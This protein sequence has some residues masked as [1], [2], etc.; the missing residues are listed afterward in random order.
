MPSFELFRSC[1][2][3]GLGLRGSGLHAVMF[4]CTHKGLELMLLGCFPGQL[5]VSV[6][7][8]RLPY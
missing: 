3:L 6:L 8:V 2:G 7:V 1:K 5:Q 4:L